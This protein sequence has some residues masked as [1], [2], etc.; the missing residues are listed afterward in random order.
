MYHGPFSGFSYCRAAIVAD[1]ASSCYDLVWL[2][3]WAEPGDELAAAEDFADE[4]GLGE[5]VMVKRLRRS[6]ARRGKCE[7]PA[8]CRCEDRP[9]EL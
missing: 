2:N 8:E 4:H 3:Y 1:R 5:V 6:D 9:P 7:E